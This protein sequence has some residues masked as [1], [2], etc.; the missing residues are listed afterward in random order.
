MYGFQVQHIR[1][2][3]IG[4]IVGSTHYNKTTG[5][6]E[7]VVIWEDHTFTSPMLCDIVG[8]AVEEQEGKQGDLLSLVPPDGTKH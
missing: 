1:D 2:G 6:P 4:M 8:V 7:V 3:R 5:V